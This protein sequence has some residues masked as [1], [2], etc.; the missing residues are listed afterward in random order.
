M[1]ATMLTRNAVRFSIYAVSVGLALVM[2]V[3][4]CEQGAAPAAGGGADAG[5]TGG[6]AADARP[7][8]IVP[9]GRFP[10]G[11][12]LYEATDPRRPEPQTADPGDHRRVVFRAWYPAENP[13]DLPTAPYFLDAREGQLNAQLL[14]LPADAFVSVPTHAVRDA[15]PAP[16]QNRFPVVIF[17]PGKDTP[18]ALYSYLLEDL[19]SHGYVVFAVSHPFG[20]GAV[21]FADG[22][23]APATGAVTATQTRDQAILTWSADQRLV[24]ATIDNLDDDRL[25]GR[26][27]LSRLAV[28]GHSL[29]GAAAAHSCLDELRFRACANMDGSVGQE[30]LDSALIQPF[31][32]LRAAGLANAESTLAAFFDSLRG[33]SYRVQLQGAGHNTF[34]DIGALVSRLRLDGIDLDAAQLQLGALPAERGYELVSRHL[35][36]FFDTHL[37][38]ANSPILQAPS[39]FPEVTLELRPGRD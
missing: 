6:A 17:S 7:A 19:A 15:L 29:G 25:A 35:V 12:A 37:R 36:A 31:L 24:L 16:G 4:G 18:A 3:T 23:V 33:I 1:T 26:L 14:S 28:F 21:V 5:V 22:Q 8:G 20:S 2:S 27:D 10:V 9:S 13:A 30:V 39:A 11:T 38:G 34:S 32:L